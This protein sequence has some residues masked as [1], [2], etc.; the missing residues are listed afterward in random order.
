MIFDSKIS[1]LEER[2]NLGTLSMDKL[3]GIF[4][5]YDMRTKQLNPLTKE[6]TFKASK[7]INKKHRKNSKPSCNCN[8]DSNEYEE[9]DNFIRKL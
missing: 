5:T 7:N 8:D 4:T 2:A 6:E 1:S 9:M 3:H